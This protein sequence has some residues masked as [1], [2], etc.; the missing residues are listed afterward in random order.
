M[1]KSEL[2]EL[3]QVQNDTKYL[4]KFYDKLKSQYENQY[5][6]IKDGKI[7]AN[8]KTIDGILKYLEA[9]KIDSAKVLIEFLTPKDMLLI[10]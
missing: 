6:A 4:I 10:L 9:K 2:Q 3:I 7:I 5:V 8:N 1:T